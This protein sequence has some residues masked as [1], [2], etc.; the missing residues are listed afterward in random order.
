MSEYIL[1]KYSLCIL[2]FICINHITH[3]LSI[4][5]KSVAILQIKIFT[6]TRK[7]NFSPFLYPIIQGDIS[8]IEDALSEI[9]NI[10]L[11][12][13]TEFEN[14]EEIATLKELNDNLDV[15]MVPY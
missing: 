5:H 14:T 8:E 6:I 4:L 9:E 12:F 7:F 3:F 11:P 1:K 13:K 2:F 10:I 15:L